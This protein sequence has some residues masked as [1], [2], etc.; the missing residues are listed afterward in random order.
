MSHSQSLRQLL[1]VRQ[2]EEEQCRTSL[3]SALGELNRLDRAL[4]ASHERERRGRALV[5]A[6]FYLPVTSAVKMAEIIEVSYPISEQSI[7]RRAGL[8]DSNAALK[9]IESLKRRLRAQQEQVDQLRAAFL[10]RRV[11][12]RQAETLIIEEN[13]RHLS[14]VEHRAQQAIDDWYGGRLT[15]EKQAVDRANNS[16]VDKD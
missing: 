4:T 7:D 12:R 2:L 11:E 10:A 13:T 6:S 15:R 1:R 8:E 9:L 3:E 16:A 5:K 14:E